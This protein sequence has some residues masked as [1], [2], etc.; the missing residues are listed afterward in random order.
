MIKSNPLVSIVTPAYNCSCTLSETIESVLSQAFSDWEMLIVDDGS[1]DDSYAVAKFYMAQD[2]R[3]R[4]VR[5][6]RN[7]GAGP[8][9][10]YGLNLANGRFIAFLDADDVWLEHK[11]ERQVAFMLNNDVSFSYHD[12]DM[13]DEAGKLVKS[14]SCP[15]ELNWNQYIKNTA[16]GVLTI[17]IDRSRVDI[18]KMPAQPATEAVS[19]WISI[20][21]VHGPAVKVPGV[22]ASYRVR[23]GS[24]S[25][26][27][28]KSAYWYWRSLTDHVGLSRHYSIYVVLVAGLRAFAKNSRLPFL[29]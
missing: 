24:V 13:I 21:M 25:R 22:Y 17:M 8:A 7:S 2:E 14:I 29:K 4:A 19:V 11:L 5:L 16:I 27:K 26:N 9:R 15:E 28:I 18:P 1:T 6:E 20:L 3:V 23:S 10:N 12:Y